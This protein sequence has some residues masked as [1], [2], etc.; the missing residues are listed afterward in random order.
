MCLASI[1][2]RRTKHNCGIAFYIVFFRRNCIT[3]VTHVLHRQCPCHFQTQAI[4]YCSVFYLN[5][6]HWHTL[7]R[8]RTIFSKEPLVMDPVG[9]KWIW[10]IYF[11]S[12]NCY[13]VKCECQ[14]FT[15]VASSHYWALKFPTLFLYIQGSIVHFQLSF[16]TFF[17]FFKKK[18]NFV[19]FLLFSVRFS[20]EVWTW[21]RTNYYVQFH[22]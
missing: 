12:A 7:Y 1:L 6:H 21:N 13:V 2:F 10:K 8:F 3:L 5:H 15:Y 20:V 4:N 18:L 17:S 16:R 22:F 19:R 11:A 14:F 9:G